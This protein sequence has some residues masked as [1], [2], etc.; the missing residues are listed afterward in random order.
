M[1]KF[2][3]FVKQWNCN[4]YKEFSRCS[5]FKISCKRVIISLD[6]VHYIILALKNAWFYIAEGMA[7]CYNL[8]KWLI[9][10]QYQL[11]HTLDDITAVD[12]ENTYAMSLY[13]H[14]Y[15]LNLK[16]VIVMFPWICPFIISILLAEYFL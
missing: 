4:A 16:E 12:W 5:F 3:P 1:R 11:F 2:C 14:I 10:H 13:V 15:A 8:N 6:L 7:Y 9:S